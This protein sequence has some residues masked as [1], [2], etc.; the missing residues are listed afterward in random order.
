MSDGVIVLRMGLRVTVVLVYSW[1]CLTTA[2][3][4]GVHG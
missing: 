3:T 2:L 4:E 1:A